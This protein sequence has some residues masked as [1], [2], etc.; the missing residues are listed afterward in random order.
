MTIK[1]SIRYFNKTPIRSIWDDDNKMWLYAAVDV[2]T[3]LINSNN[4][5]IY[6]NSLKR[7]NPELFTN[8]IQLKLT[9]RDGKKYLTDVIPFEDVT[10][11]I[12]RIRSNNSLEFLK[13]IN[14]LSNPIEEQSRVR[15][16]ELYDNA[17]LKT[18]I[19]IYG[20]CIIN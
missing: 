3:A 5:R 18:F 17:I 4:P 11:A 1:T 10:N 7:R 2:V 16:Y 20:F 13:W 6:W 14:G 9:A 8:C 12:F 15:A 19:F